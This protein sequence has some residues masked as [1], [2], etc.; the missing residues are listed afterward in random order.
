MRLADLLQY[1]QI[2]IQAH[3]DPDADAVGSGYALYRYF[4]SHGK[5]VRLV[6]GG[7]NPISKSNMKLMVAELDIPIEHV[8]ELE[9][10]E[11]LLTVDCQY[12]EGNV[13]KFEAQ[14]G[15]DRPSRDRQ[16]VR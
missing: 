5:D 10:P 13:Q 15:G 4:Q 3:N 2:V 7:R 8:Q 1:G 11:L 9:P 12:G 16:G 14:C 6:Y